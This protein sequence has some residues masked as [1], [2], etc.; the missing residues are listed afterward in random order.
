LEALLLELAA[1]GLETE[2]GFWSWKKG[3]KRFEEVGGYRAMEVG[4]KRRGR[5]EERRYGRVWS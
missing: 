3:G 1:F 2:V 4:G 5:R